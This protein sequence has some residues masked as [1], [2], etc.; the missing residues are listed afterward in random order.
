M[1]VQKALSRV[2]RIETAAAGSG[3]P[4]VYQN[5]PGLPILSLSE[6]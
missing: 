4:T 5:P 1:E 6:P 3:L 2:Q